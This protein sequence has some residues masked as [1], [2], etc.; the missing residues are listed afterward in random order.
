MPALSGHEGEV[1]HLIS[2]LSNYVLAAG[3]MNS[4]KR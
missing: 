2:N 3:A 4:L 1:M